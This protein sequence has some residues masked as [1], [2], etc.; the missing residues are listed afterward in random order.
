MRRLKILAAGMLLELA[1]AAGVWAQS[2][3]LPALPGVAGN[4]GP[5]PTYSI[6]LQTRHACV[7]PHSQKLARAEGGFIDVT[8]PAPNTVTAVLTGTAAANS[9]LGCTGSASETF[10]LVQDFEIE[11][12]DPKVQSV[13]LTL[14]T[15]LVGFVRSKGRAGACVRRAE[16]SVTPV[17]LPDAPLAQAYPAL[18]SEGTG[19]QLCNQHLPPLVIPVMPVGRYTMVVTFVLDT[20][21]SGVCDSHAVADFS[22][23]TAL[24]PDWVRTR[25]PFQGVS[26]KSFGFTASVSAAPPTAGASGPSVAAAPRLRLMRAPTTPRA[27]V[28]VDWL[29][30]RQRA[31]PSF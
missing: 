11:C 26:K 15:A 4:G 22:P 10:Q 3:A 27:T 8:L 12:S 19:G 7:T 13:G 6:T 31:R 29:A 2:P 9:Y 17:G 28:P 14:D 21:A 24:P 23:D 1:M 20:R 25:D 5:P 30:E 16:V 18:T